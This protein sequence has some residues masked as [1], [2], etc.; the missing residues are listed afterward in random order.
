MN[1][2]QAIK[3]AVEEL[4]KENDLP[5]PVQ[6]DYFKFLEI[7][8]APEV[9]TVLKPFVK[10]YP[11]LQELLEGG[12]GEVVEFFKQVIKDWQRVYTDLKSVNQV[13]WGVLSDND[14]KS[15]RAR[16]LAGKEISEN[17]KAMLDRHNILLGIVEKY[18]ALL[19]RERKAVPLTNINVIVNTPNE[20]AYTLQNAHLEKHELDSRE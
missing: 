16:V 20:I 8:V 6:K 9:I 1:L 3:K 4:K 2:E 7:E 19:T 11:E 15:V 10:Y 12:E 14:N 13:L 18:L 5:K 17:T